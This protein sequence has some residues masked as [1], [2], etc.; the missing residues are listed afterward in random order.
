M[1]DA[2]AA[3]A[4]LGRNP[5]CE[6]SFDCW[7]EDAQWQVH[8]VTGGRNDREWKLLAEGATP[9]QA[10]LSAMKGKRDA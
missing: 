2:A 10:L 5:N 6:L 3:L 9:L 8:R 4:W 7:A 1:S